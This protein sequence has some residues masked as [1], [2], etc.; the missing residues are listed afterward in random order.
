MPADARVTPPSL[1]VVKRATGGGD[2]KCSRYKS[3]RKP[4]RTV[5]VFWV[6]K[7]GKTL[8]IERRIRLGGISYSGPMKWWRTAGVVGVLAVYAGWR[9]VDGINYYGNATPL[10]RAILDRRSDRSVRLI[11]GGAD[12]HA[13]MYAA[14][15]PVTWGATPLHLAAYMD[16]LDV[17]QAL[18]D[19]GADK[20][21]TDDRGGTPLQTA[22]MASADD[23][24]LL[25]VR[26]GAR[27]W[28]DGATR[29]ESRF[30]E[31]LAEALG[32]CSVRVVRALIDAGADPH[33][34][35]GPDAMARVGPPEM[36]EKY[37]LLAARG[38][39]AVEG[40]GRQAIHAA[41]AADDTAAVS[42]L[43]DLGV[44]IESRSSDRIGEQY[45]NTALIE[46]AANGSDAVVRLLV[47]RGA[48]VRAGATDY[49]SALYAAA[50]EGHTHTVKLLLSIAPSIDVQRGR[51]SDRATPLH[52]AYFHD[53]KEMIEALL[54][55]GADPEARTTDGRT[56]SQFG[57]P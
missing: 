26:S 2:C 52:M 45:G 14:L 28:R 7:M 20:E 47:S 22:I 36:L 29:E 31:P 23:A 32:R 48:N 6:G 53:D 27:A 19:A 41:A 1:C 33:R 17:M 34:D 15:F 12:I 42:Y 9:L 4:C 55:A 21:A 54:G 30:E 16:D 35:V 3:L 44:D 51:R 38:F 57:M 56:P 18:V 40:S 43:L 11:R 25:L 49:G 46:A 24:A 10:H 13:R 8:C 37:E 39:S 50:H 5:R